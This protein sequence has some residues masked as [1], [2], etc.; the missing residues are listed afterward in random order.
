MKV[1]KFIEYITFLQD[2]GIVDENTE[3]M[4]TSDPQQDYDRTSDIKF[5]VLSKNQ[6]KK[7]RELLLCDPNNDIWK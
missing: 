1:D 4:V 2:S 3:I 5:K 6:A 7:A